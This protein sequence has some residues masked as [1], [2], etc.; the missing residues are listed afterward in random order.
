MTAIFASDEN[1]SYFGEQNLEACSLPLVIG[2]LTRTDDLG[3]R[4]EELSFWVSRLSGG[5]WRTSSAL[6]G[7]GN[8][9]VLSDMT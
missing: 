8:K 3:L 4:A 1:I 7:L 5:A 6:P 9:F 2:L